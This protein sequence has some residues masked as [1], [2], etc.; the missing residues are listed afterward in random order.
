MA[1]APWQHVNVIAR[2]IGASALRSLAVLFQLGVV[3][4]SM[5]VVPPDA[6]HDIVRQS[7]NANVPHSRSRL[8]IRWSEAPA[9]KVCYKLPDA[10]VVPRRCEGSI[11]SENAHVSSA[12][13]SPSSGAAMMLPGPLPAA[14]VQLGVVMSLMQNMLPG[15][16]YDFVRRCAVNE[17]VCASIIICSP[18]FGA[19]LARPVYV[20][21][22][23]MGANAPRSHSFPIILQSADTSRRY[24]AARCTLPVLPLVILL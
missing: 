24:E 16:S 18:S 22:K 5:P 2:E 6:A 13:R 23:Q 20:L 19:V 8:V 10:V 1:E 15:A 4:L 9:W 3:M 14:Y 21:G 7:M 12:K 11:V 17:C